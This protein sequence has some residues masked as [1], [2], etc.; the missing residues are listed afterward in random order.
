MATITLT[1]GT[2]TRTATISATDL[3]RVV[4]AFK[5][6]YGAV[7]TNQQAFDIWADGTVQALRDIVRGEELNTT[8]ANDTAAFVGPVIT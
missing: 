7:L 1:I 2:F 8:I 6:R 5:S 4:A 3:N